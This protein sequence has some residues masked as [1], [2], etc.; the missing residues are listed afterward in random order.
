MPD[1]YMVLDRQSLFLELKVGKVSHFSPR[2]SQL[3]WNASHSLSGGRS[4]FLLR[5]PSCS[6]LF[7]F[8]ALYGLPRELQKSFVSRAEKLEMSA[9]I[10]EGD[11][12]ELVDGLRTVV[13]GPAS[14]A[15][16][17]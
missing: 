10:W 2:P 12:S 14:C 11:L 3:A 13:L 7:L 16:R 5:D 6:S 4:A 17:P 15:L 8:S 1:V 9:P